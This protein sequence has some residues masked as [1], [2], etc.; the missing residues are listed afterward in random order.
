[1]FEH[2]LSQKKMIRSVWSFERKFYSW[3]KVESL[4][5]RQRQHKRPKRYEG[6]DPE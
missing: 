4:T 5:Y 2:S 6:A 3:D 1:M